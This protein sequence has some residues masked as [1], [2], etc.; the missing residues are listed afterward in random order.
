MK[1]IVNAD[2]SYIFHVGI[3]FYCHCNDRG[4]STLV[5][6]NLSEHRKTH[7]I[8]CP[9]M[10]QFVPPPSTCYL[11]SCEYSHWL[12]LSF[13]SVLAPNSF[14]EVLLL[15]EESPVFDY[16]SSHLLKSKWYLF[17]IFFISLSENYWDFFNRILKWKNDF[18]KAVAN[19]LPS[20]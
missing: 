3:W 16:F 18:I 7:S 14:S 8:E 10:E 12:K 19:M 5:G 1:N 15:I 11:P 6:S 20:A 13:L 9:C 2:K 17:N 4:T